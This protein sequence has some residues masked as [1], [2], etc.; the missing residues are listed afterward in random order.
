[1]PSGRPRRR[2]TRPRNCAKSEPSTSGTTALRGAPVLPL[3][4]RMKTSFTMR[5]FDIAAAAV[6][7]GGDDGGGGEGG[8]GR[9]GGPFR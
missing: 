1:M 7:D 4:I 6:G 3:S 8:G 5:S 2:R 9:C